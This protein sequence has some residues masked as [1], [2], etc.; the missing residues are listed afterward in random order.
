MSEWRTI[1]SAPNDQTNVLVFLSSPLDGE[2]IFIAHQNM[3]GDW[4][5]CP[6]DEDGSFYLVRAA[7]RGITH[8]MP[9]PEPPK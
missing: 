9:L 1:D 4:T 7:E 3:Y 2:F 6:V 5:S 8:W